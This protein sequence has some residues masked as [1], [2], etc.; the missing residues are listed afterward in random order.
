MQNINATAFQSRYF[1]QG[2][3]MEPTRAPRDIVSMAKK[4][5]RLSL[6]PKKRHFIKEWR[7]Y[8]KLTQEKLAT[9]LDI[10]TSHISQIERGTINYTRETL[11]AIAYALACEPAD[12]LGRDPN[13]PDNELRMII[14]NL[15]PDMQPRVLRVVKALVSEAA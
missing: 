13:R 11:E 5:T 8:R 7:R 15:A 2:Y 3:G 9:R 1:L 6:G 12:L 4:R 14:D 10:S